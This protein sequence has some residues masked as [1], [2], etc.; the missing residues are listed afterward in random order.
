MT[1]LTALAAPARQEDDASPRPLPWRRMTWVTWR[2]HR[3]AL[4]GMAALLGALTVYMWITGLRLHHAY[5]AAIACHPA[6]SITCS[7]LIGTFNTMGGFLSSGFVLQAVPALIGA[8]VGAPLLAREFE[9]GTTRYAWTQGFGRVRWALAKVVLL[10]VVVTAAAGAVSV[11]FSWYYQPY[12]PTGNPALSIAKQVPFEA[13]PFAPG[14]FDLRGVSFA[15]WTLAAFSIGTLAGTLIRRVV[16]AIVVALAVYA[17][18]AI[19]AGGFLRQHYLA[20]LVTSRLTVPGSAW[21]ISQQWM[22][23]GGRPASP[24]ALDRVLQGTQFPGKGGVPQSLSAWQY[25]VQ[26][27]YT[28]WTTYQPASRFWAFQWIEGGWLLALSVLLIGV[29]LWLVGRRAV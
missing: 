5:D 22:T 20:P 14:L 8:F 11:I 6:G 4:T 17:G 9:T 21:I 15:A 24:A 26:H 19:A 13:S 1:A 28:Q 12:F 7:D 16:P 29:T 3:T 2:Q 27:G 18:L 25:L 10:A 23:V